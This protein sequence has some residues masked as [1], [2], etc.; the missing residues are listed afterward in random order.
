MNKCFAAIG[1]CAVIGTYSIC[2]DTTGMNMESRVYAEDQATEVSDDEDTSVRGTWDNPGYT[3][4]GSEE[5][6]VPAGAEAAFV[7]HDTEDPDLAAIYDDTESAAALYGISLPSSYVS[8]AATSVKDQGDY[9]VCWA[10]ATAAASEASLRKEGLAGA[11]IDLSEWQ[12]AYYLNHRTT[13]PLGLTSGD[14][15]SLNTAYIQSV[16]PTHSVDAQNAYMYAGA[17]CEVATKMLADWI[18]VVPESKAGYETIKKD[19]HAGLSDSLCYA[20]DAYHLENAY[21]IAMKDQSAIKSMLMQYGAVASSYCESAA[22]LNAVNYSYYCPEKVGSNHAITIIG[23]DDNYSRTNFRKQPSGNGAWLCKNSW[24]SSWG[25]AIGGSYGYCWISYEDGSLLNSNGYVFDYGSA[26]NYMHNY[27]Y[28]GGYQNGYY[29]NANYSANIYTAASSQELR[30][31]GYYTYEPN[32]TVT[33]RIYKGSLTNP[34]DG[35]I[36]ASYTAEEP[37]AGYHTMKLAIPVT[38]SVNERFSVVMQ[39]SSSVIGVDATNTGFWYEAVSAARRGQSYISDDGSSWYDVSK[40]NRNC[41]IKAYTVDVSLSDVEAFC[42]RLYRTCLQREPDPSGLNAWSELLQKQEATGANVGYGFVFS[43]EYLNKHT[44]NEEY[45]EMLYQVYLD[46]EPDAQGKAGW[47]DLLDHGISREHVFHG[48]VESPEYSALC[49]R[50]GIVRGAYS[51]DQARDRNE[52]LTRYLYRM[53]TVALGRPA[54]IDGLNAWCEAVLSGS[55]STE[56]A[57]EGFILSAEFRNKNLSDEDYVRILYLTFFDRE[58]DP[59]GYQT[60]VDCLRAGTSREEVLHGF[61]RSPE[62]HQLMSSYGL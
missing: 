56:Q 47:V 61:S 36:A 26:D 34:T 1:I 8:D 19:S 4:Q 60:W 37:Y 40:D 32:V 57:S 44:T 2:V 62:F 17:N 5:Y 46:R 31:V 45:V 3:Y 28:D 23:W 14:T 20:S 39:Q 24:G 16:N 15:F 9:G 51:S 55:G 6:K 10:F 42:T 43:Q 7:R 21:W 18:G 59:N 52:G 50:Y 22:Y 54:D 27:Q 11:D 30:A 41:R 58:P 53:Y 25:T 35:T 33:V 29:R 12:M 13:D 38:L 49:D 48:F